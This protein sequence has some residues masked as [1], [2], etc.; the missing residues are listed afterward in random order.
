MTDRL[1]TWCAWLGVALAWIAGPER[2]AADDR[3]RVS[4]R[5]PMIDPTST[6]PGITL[7]DAHLIESAMVVGDVHPTHLPGARGGSGRALGEVGLVAGHGLGGGG[8]A[9]ELTVGLA[10]RAARRYEL[11]ATG[12]VTLRSHDRAVFAM[13]VSWARWS[14][15]RSLGLRLGAGAS[16]IAGELGAAWRAELVLPLPRFGER[17]QPIATLGVGGTTAGDDHTDVGVGLGLRF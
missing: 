11:G 4:L 9:T 5:A 7:S 10:L 2:A 17:A 3:I 15:V 1:V 16:G 8:L 14:I 12:R 6:Y 13:L